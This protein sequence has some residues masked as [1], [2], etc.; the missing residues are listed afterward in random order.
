MHDQHQH[1]RMAQ[2]QPKCV[3]PNVDKAW[4]R[5]APDLEDHQHHA[6]REDLVCEAQ[7]VGWFRVLQNGQPVTLKKSCQCSNQGQSHEKSRVYSS[8]ELADGFEV[9]CGV[10]SQPKVERESEY[11]LAV[12]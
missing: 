10:A 3:P 9:L 2:V 8:K 11:R 5:G 1:D 12:L 7:S 6:D 4:P